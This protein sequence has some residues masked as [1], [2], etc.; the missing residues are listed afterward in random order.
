MLKTA[1]KFIAAVIVVSLPLVPALA[2]RADNW[3]LEFPTSGTGA[4][5]QHFREGVTSMHLH[6][7]ED[8]EEHFQVAQQLAPDFVMAY[9]GEALAQHR[10]I[11]NIH[12]LERA[13][14][15]L[16]RLGA[17]PEARAAKAET[18]RERQYLT[19]VEWLFG[20]G[21]Q[22]ERELAYSNAMAALSRD[23]PE[24]SEAKA[25]Y[26]LSLMRI[27]SPGLTREQTRSL[28]ASLS[29]EVLSDN[30]RHPG[31]NRYLIQSTDDPE[32]TDLG[33][34][35]VNN[36][37]PIE[38]DA[39]EALH[40]PSHYYLQHGMWTET[41][42]SNWR[43]FEA[44]MVWVDEH[45]WNLEDLN[46][47]NYGHL[48][49]FA[50]YGY[51]QSGQLAAAAGIRERVS[52]DFIAS[53]KAAEIRAP[54]VDTHARYLVDLERW[55]ETSHLLAIAREHSLQD[56]GLWLAIG[57]GAARSGD[58]DLAREAV[59]ILDDAGGGAASLG[60]IS[61]REVESL[62]LAAQ[63]RTEAALAML[64]QAAEANWSRPVTR[65]GV[66]PRPLK[67]VL[68]L[69]GEE[70]LTSGAAEEAL[71]QFERGL[72]LYRGRNNLLAGAARAAEAVGK[73]EIARGYRDRLAANRAEADEN[74][75]SIT[76]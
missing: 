66:P 8:A 23:L 19:A 18:S 62:V 72:T 55:D 56:A 31:A 53:N 29:L 75:R 7:F 59:A 24:D 13:Q 54:Y 9:W 71:L 74:T 33:I 40:I 47:H 58:L 34:I 45:G 70:L 22:P 69:L 30:S 10:T 43:A 16:G 26:A 20:D 48:L 61:A 73:H 28:M 39:A 6:M 25:W 51:L 38:T 64:R 1:Q 37:R 2:Q 44:S 63:G 12:R 15:I 65:I 32:N 5:Q 50:N 35:A 46:S 27:N 42:E 11:W 21:S 52:S 17:T 14:A 36:L 76:H 4:A 57:I 41:A 68:E 49:Q 3:N 67:P 60:N